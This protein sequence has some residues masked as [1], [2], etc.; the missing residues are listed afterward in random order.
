MLVCGM[1]KCSLFVRLSHTA[2]IQEITFLCL[3]VALVF[4]FV[5]RLLCLPS[6][7][8]PTTVRRRSFFVIYRLVKFKVCYHIHLFQ[9]A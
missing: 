9:E 3:H 4:V 8:Q 7:P 5:P 1:M 2:Q 6:S